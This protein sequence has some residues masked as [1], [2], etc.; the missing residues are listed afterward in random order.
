MSPNDP[1]VTFLGLFKVSI[2]KLQP[3]YLNSFHNGG[4]IG[5]GS[6]YMLLQKIGIPKM[7]L[8]LF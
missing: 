5:M 3:T 4:M 8:W 1:S 6:I 7:T 2:I